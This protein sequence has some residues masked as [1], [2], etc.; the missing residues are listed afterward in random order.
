MAVFN[1]NYRLTG[2][3]G[4]VPTGW[5]A[6]DKDNMTWVPQYAYPAVRDT[7]VCPSCRTEILKSLK[8]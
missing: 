3:Q 1:I 8:S 2:D 6:T 4:L 7:K 5:P